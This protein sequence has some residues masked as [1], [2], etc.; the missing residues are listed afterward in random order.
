[1]KQFSYVNNFPNCRTITSLHCGTSL[2]PKNCAISH[3]QGVIFRDSGYTSRKKVTKSNSKYSSVSQVFMISN[4]KMP[5]LYL[6]NGFGMNVCSPIIMHN[7]QY[8][9]TV[10]RMIIKYLGWAGVVR[11]DGP[12]GE[13][14]LK[15]SITRK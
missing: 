4:K 15:S 6:R 2:L 3:E 11:T 14:R 9:Q 7:F 1:M 12:A 10:I 8:L 13:K 5:A